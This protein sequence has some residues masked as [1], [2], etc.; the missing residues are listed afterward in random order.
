MGTVGAASLAVLLAACGGGHVNQH[1]P[2]P[3]HSPSAAT[4]TASGPATELSAYPV[5]LGV[6]H[7]VDKKNHP[8]SAPTPDHRFPRRYSFA[9]NATD[10]LYRPG[11]AV[12]HNVYLIAGQLA[13]GV[14]PAA[15]VQDYLGFF[16]GQEVHLTTEPAGALGGTVKCWVANGVTFCMWADNG[17]YGV[18]DYEPPLALDTVTI[19]HLAGVT[20]LFRQAM[21]RVKH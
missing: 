1:H 15:A 6:Y 10:G 13:Q 17:T 4:R 14:S 9:V 5:R 7:L 3:S 12:D 20:A 16:Q 21:V 2:A 19:H 8:V 11:N 18:F